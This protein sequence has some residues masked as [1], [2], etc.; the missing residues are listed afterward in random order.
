VGVGDLESP[1][2]PADVGPSATVL[3][4]ELTPHVARLLSEARPRRVWYLSS[5]RTDHSAIEP[6]WRR[7]CLVPSALHSAEDD[8]ARPL[9]IHVPVNPLARRHHHHGFGFTEYILVLAGAR[10]ENQV[11]VPPAAA[12][13]TAALPAQHVIVVERATASAWKGR[14]LRGRVPVDTR[15][16]LLRLLAHAAVCVD[17]SPGSYI[18]RE[19]VEALRLGT[20]IVAPAA[21]ETAA[22]H[23]AAGGGAVFADPGE[24]LD[25]VERLGHGSQSDSAKEAGQ[26]YADTWYGDPTRSVAQLETLLQ[27]GS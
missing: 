2:W 5:G 21:S 23:A 4:D 17:L 10:N 11:S 9:T 26:R 16:D 6:G 22:A 14:A 24:L 18:A 27:A 3:T 13:L 25:A 20:P 7:L 12:W 1:S 8:A 15:M 19:C